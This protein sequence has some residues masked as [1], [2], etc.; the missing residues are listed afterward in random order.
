MAF[1]YK[2]YVFVCT[3]KRDFFLAEMIDIYNKQFDKKLQPG[4]IHTKYIQYL[5]NTWLKNVQ[6]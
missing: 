6:N 5:F 2:G 1:V 4:D 3:Y